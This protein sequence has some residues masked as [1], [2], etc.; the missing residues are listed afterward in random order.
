[1]FSVMRR[2]FV[3]VSILLAAAAVARAQGTTGSISGTITDGQKAGRQNDATR[4]RNAGSSV[5]RQLV[6]GS[7]ERW[8]HRARA[9]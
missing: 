2:L 5:G 4:E 7:G 8:P 9:A 3:C 1:M 6:L